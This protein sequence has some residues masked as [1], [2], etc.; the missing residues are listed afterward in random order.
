MF[1]NISGFT[2]IELTMAMSAAALIV[3]AAFP[4]YSKMIEKR[5]LSY[6]AEHVSMFLTAARSEAVIRNQ[7]I[8]VSM[9]SQSGGADWC[10][11][12]K[13]GGDNCD[14]TVSDPSH[15][16]F[17]EV[18]GNEKRLLSIASNKSVTAEMIAMQMGPVAIEPTR[19]MLSN[20]ASCAVLDL[21][22]FNNNYSLEVQLNQ[23][24]RNKVC[25]EGGKAIAGYASCDSFCR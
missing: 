19:G 23:T 21:A 11:G 24:G 15:A 6:Q 16:D 25:A 14:C 7:V 17:C 8:S 4:S 12:I 1:K 20:P 3:T 13:D 22:S 10:V 2:L 18:A 5:K 9:M